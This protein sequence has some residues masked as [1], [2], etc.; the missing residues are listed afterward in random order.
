M[1]YSLKLRIGNLVIKKVKY[2]VR[3]LKNYYKNYLNLSKARSYN[4]WAITNETRCF[5]NTEYDQ[6]SLVSI[7]VPAYNPEIGHFFEMVYS[8]VNQHYQNWELVI[9][10]ASSNKK[11][12]EKIYDTTEIDTRIKIINSENLGIS[13]NTNLGINEAKGKFIVFFDHDDL[14]HPCALHSIFEKQQDEKADVVYTDEDKISEDSKI[15]FG[16]HCKPNWS[17][18]LFENLN[19]INHLTA[20]RSDFVKK[21]GG[22][23][24]E[25]DGAQDYDLLLRIIDE[26]SPKI[27]HVSRVLYHWRAAKT[28]TAKSINTKKYIFSAGQNSLQEHF[29]RNKVKAKVRIIENKPGFYRPEYPQTQTSVIIGLIE[30]PYYG[31]CAK[32]ITNT[33]KDHNLDKIII[34]EWVKK[35]NLQIQGLTIIKDHNKYFSEALQCVNTDTVVVFNIMASL[36]NDLSAL[37]ELSSTARTLNK[38]VQPVIINGEGFIIDS[39]LVES[40]YG[41]QPLFKG[42]RVGC[43]TYFGDT[44][45]VRNIS[46]VGGFIYAG[47][48]DLIK[49]NIDQNGYPDY[50][51]SDSVVWP[52]SK[53]EFMSI[54]RQETNFK[55][56]NPQISQSMFAI[57]MLSE[58]WK[59]DMDRS[60]D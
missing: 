13:E 59:Q 48:K 50:G 18:Q 26:F 47:P 49:K 42:L 43:N 56:F 36:N 54:I 58:A 4:D 9:V 19:Y 24:K 28:S 31:V 25:Y 52:H 44:D 15:Y 38:I 6:K 55:N 21:I 32:W 53:V 30:A 39:G 20:I 14:L 22:L 41:L 5:V 8:V 29:D 16:P 10:N 57:N 17:P 35:Y 46:S 12:N 60:D 27:S 2:I 1:Q 7:I 40:S 45:W 11:I 3:P 33:F 51:K 37:A 23:R 34:G